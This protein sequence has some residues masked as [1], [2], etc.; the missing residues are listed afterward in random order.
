MIEQTGERFEWHY[1]TGIKTYLESLVGDEVAPKGLIG[2]SNQTDDMQ[3]E[4]VLGWQTPDAV[5][6]PAFA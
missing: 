5:W 2:L 3:V 1:E 4:W 6:P